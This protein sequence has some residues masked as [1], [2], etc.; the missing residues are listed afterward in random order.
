MKQSTRHQQ[1]IELAQ[2][3]GFVSTDELVAS[4]KVSPQTIR[5]DL[6]ELSEL[7]QIRRHHGGASVLE[8]SV[9]NDPYASRKIRLQQEKQAIAKSICEQIPD[10]ASLFLDIGTTSETIA[11]GLLNHK[12]LRVVTNNLNVASILMPKQDF[13]VIVAGGEVRNRDGGI[14]GEATIDFIKQFRL[15]FGIVTVS[16]IDLDGS[17]LDFDYHEVR[18]TQ[19]IISSA[20]HVMLAADHTK[21]ARNAMVNIG[22]IRQL[23]Q[24][25]SDKQAPEPLLKQIEAS[26][27]KFVLCAI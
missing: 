15:D 13:K 19:A 4:F 14:V 3:Q 26:D 11:Q 23:D 7:Q 18:V 2:A 6:N 8:S 17:L 20:R 25:F 1:I 21:F 27:V 22:H 5:R 12:D 10:G 16:G 9:T 24:I